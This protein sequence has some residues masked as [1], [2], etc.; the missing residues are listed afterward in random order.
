MADGIKK[1]KWQR[2]SWINTMKQVTNLNLEILNEIAKQ[3]QER[4][5]VYI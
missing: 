3:N 2:T 1:Q 4:D 5:I